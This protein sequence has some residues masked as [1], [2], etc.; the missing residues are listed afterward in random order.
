MDNVIDRCQY[1][2]VSVRFLPCFIPTDHPPSEQHSAE[3]AVQRSV[4]CVNDRTLSIVHLS[5]T[6]RHKSV[7]YTLISIAYLD[8]SETQFSLLV[9]LQNLKCVH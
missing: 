6:D 5:N 4:K 8:I 3:L 7:L 1:V 2:C 9:L